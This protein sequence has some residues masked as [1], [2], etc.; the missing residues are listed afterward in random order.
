MICSYERKKYLNEYSHKLYYDDLEESVDNYGLI[1]LVDY[2]TW[3]RLVNGT[4]RT[5]ILDHVFTND[6]TMISD[7][8]PIEVILGDHRLVLF[9]IEEKTPKPEATYL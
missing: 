4:W 2:D 7:V 5:S 3:S 8:R 6:E 9:S 1:Q